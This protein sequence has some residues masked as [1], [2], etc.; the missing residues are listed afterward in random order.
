MTNLATTAVSD[1]SLPYSGGAEFGGC[2]DVRFLDTELAI[3]EGNDLIN[4]LLARGVVVKDVELV[5][6]NLAEMRNA[7]PFLYDLPD[8]VRESFD[9]ARLVM[10]V[11]EAESESLDTSSVIADRR[12]R[13]EIWTE[14]SAEDAFQS[15]SALNE[16]WVSSV[17]ENDFSR[18]YTVVRFM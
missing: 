1:F 15:A 16:G 11:P 5:Q 2:S 6:R 8:K 18:F 12:V 9:S 3:E 7:L 10:G 14:Q 4:Y 17:A 13:V